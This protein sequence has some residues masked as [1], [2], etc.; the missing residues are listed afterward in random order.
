MKRTV[1][2][3]HQLHSAYSLIEMAVV[4]VIIG[5][6]V[7]TSLSLGATQLKI[8]RISGTQENLYLIRD[9]MEVFRQKHQRLPCP[10]PRDVVVTDATYGVEATSCSY[11]ACP[12]GMDCNN[13]TISGMVPFNTLGLGEK[14]ALD[15]WKSRIVYVV[16]EQHT[17]Y[18]NHESGNIIVNDGSGNELT[19]SEV[20]GRAIYVLLS[21]GP[22]A[23]GGWR[24]TGISQGA[25]D[26]TRKDGE[27]C[28]GDN[29]FTDMRP[30][31]GVI[32]ADFFDDI[33]LWYTKQE[34]NRLRAYGSGW[35]G[36]HGMISAGSGFSC[37][38]DLNQKRYCWGSN[39]QDRS[40]LNV[41]G[42][43]YY[44][45]QLPTDE[46]FHFTDWKTLSIHSDHGCGIRREDELF[47]WGSNA[48]GKMGIGA[49]S[50]AYSSVM[51]VGTEKDWVSVSAGQYHTCGIRRNGT[52]WCWGFNNDGQIGNDNQYTSPNVPDQVTDDVGTGAWH[53]WMKISAGRKY[54]CGIRRDQTAWCW[55]QN[56]N[57]Q[58]GSA[59]P[60]TRDT[61]MQV[62]GGP[63]GWRHISAGRETTCG[64]GTDSS[65]YCWGLNDTGQVGDNTATTP[66]TS[67]KEVDGS[68]TDWDLIDSG[69][70]SSCGL[71]DGRAYCWGA[72]TNGQLGD[73]DSP[74]SSQI[75]VQVYNGYKN[76]I[77]ISVN[78]DNV[79]GMRED[80]R[81]YC[82]GRNQNGQVGD[83]T[84]T[85]R[86][87]PT[88]VSTISHFALS[89][90]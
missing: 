6:V 36:G 21:P 89:G 9:A 1:T 51:Q 71:R 87:I 40:G 23:E 67:P 24:Q 86:D 78:Q 39:A 13:F 63:K 10:A 58:L 28:D 27:N 43:V 72:N 20:L 3:H 50:G 17:L 81:F 12:S 65:A 45:P 70:D 62:T 11:T 31:D 82:W 69:Y 73:D 90:D 79:C 7:G 14:I 64:I 42:G 29:V 68:Y 75:P 44:T 19:G 61:P 57:G 25:C 5:A 49:F 22:E 53:D 8:S 54:T 83:N 56:N 35:S 46:R 74:T 77:S 41:S 47:C 15:K 84:T 30:N 85:M 32:A 80:G 4:L 66:I 55:G 88:A 37:A 60:A 52:A 76:W 38:I 2:H 26:T 34:S 18:S 33:I 16:H 48:F 59:A